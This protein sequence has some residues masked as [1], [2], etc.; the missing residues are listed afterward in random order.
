M[1]E[2][3]KTH[4]HT[5][6]HTH[7]SQTDISPKK[8]TNGQQSHEKMHHITTSAIIRQRQIKA[9]RR[10]HIHSDYYEKCFNFQK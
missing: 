2:E 3:G 6:T 4:T 8:F 10:L 9:T 7:T 5:H 1:K